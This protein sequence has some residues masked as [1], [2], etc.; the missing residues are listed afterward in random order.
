MKLIL[1]D[2]YTYIYKVVSF[3]HSLQLIVDTVCRTENI[4]SQFHFFPCAS[5][6]A[7]IDY[8]DD[9]HDPCLRTSNSCNLESIKIFPSRTPQKEHSRYKV[10]G[11]GTPSTLAVTARFPDIMPHRLLLWGCV[12]DR[13]CAIKVA[14]VEGL[15]TLITD[16]IT[17]ITRGIVGHTGRNVISTG[18]FP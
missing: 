4:L 11:S 3:I 14:E 8:C 13:V 2:G 9:I 17:T 18:C 7:V 10:W 5:Q 16:V 6:N 12:K 1:F 15:K